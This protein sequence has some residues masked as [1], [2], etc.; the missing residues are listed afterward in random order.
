MEKSITLLG[1]T[2]SIGTQTLD[3][4]KRLGIKVKA[5]AANQNIKRL[6]EQARAFR[7]RYVAVSDKNVYADL[8][9]RL[10]D[11][12]ILLLAGEEGVCELAAHDDTGMVC[13]AIVGIAGLAPTM[14]ALES[15]KDLALSNKET[16]VAAGALVTK[17]ARRQSCRILPVDSEHSAIFQCLQ[18]T[19]HSAL[20]RILLTASGGP[21]LHKTKEELKHVTFEDALKHPNWS[22]GAKITVDS[23]TLMNKGLEV[24]EAMWL[25]GVAH[26]QI[27]VIVH[28]QSIV[29]SAVEFND[30]AVI[31]QMGVPDM[32]VPIQFALT[33]PER[34]I[35]DVKPLNLPAL[36]SLTFEAPDMERFPCLKFAFDAIK[37][38]GLYPCAINSAN[39]Q[40]VALFL[41]KK[42]Q[43]C[44]ISDCIA[45]VLENIKCKVNGNYTLTDVYETDK[46]ARNMVLE[47]CGVH[48]V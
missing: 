7:P 20:R 15:K 33:Y 17:T 39:E 34:M 22:M 24:I 12:D 38:G 3:C 46:I 30:G 10:A 16:L 35:T 4:C 23:S 1:S 5:I 36:G 13:N 29:H 21:F 18:G 2:G 14:A 6:E 11:T 47:Y 19:S 45:N 40:A 31:A 37:L 32:A 44:Q 26:T 28:P 41:A 48:A 43:Y 8:K 9:L 27:E 25:F 42:V